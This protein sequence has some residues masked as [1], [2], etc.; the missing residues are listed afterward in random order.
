MAMAGKVPQRPM[1]CWEWKPLSHWLSITT[2][3]RPFGITRARLPLRPNETQLL[4]QEASLLTSERP[5]RFGCTVK[6]MRTY[7]PQIRLFGM[8]LF[9]TGRNWES[10]G[11]GSSAHS[12]YVLPCKAY[13]SIE[14][15]A[16]QYQEEVRDSCCQSWGINTKLSFH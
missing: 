3:S 9:W 11:T 1:C 16:P 12:P 8:G 5:L 2:T 13:N 4:R 15:G 10:M 6:G 7:H 14:E